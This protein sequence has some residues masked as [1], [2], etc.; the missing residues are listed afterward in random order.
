MIQSIPTYDELFQR[1]IGIL[2]EEELHTVQ[3]SKIALAGVGG[4]GGVQ[5]VALARTGISHFSIADPE[6]YQ[7]SDV[8]RQYGASISTLG[9]KKVEVMNRVVQ[10]INPQA[11]VETF[12]RGITK[13]NVDQFI[14]RADVVI[15]AIEYFALD[16]KILLA[17]KTREYSRYLIT[18]PSW[19][20]GTSMVVFSP[21]GV[22]FEEFFGVDTKEDFLIQG[23]RL[24]GRVFPLKPDYLDPYPYGEDMLEGRRPASVL[25]LGTFLSGALT[26][27][28]VLFIL[29][30]KQPIITA[31]KVIQVDLFRRSFDI[32]DLSHSKAC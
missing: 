24:A 8:N 28:E 31:P 27:A 21:Q 23:K 22:T 13:A 10:D 30:G 3:T 17:Q 2:S 32:V 16:E 20:Y 4:V 26:A 6:C 25:C 12:P 5:L 14:Q 15:D 9:C 18:S 29:L 11:C 1:N 19:G 7:A